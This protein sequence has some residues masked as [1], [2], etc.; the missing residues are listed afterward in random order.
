[1]SPGRHCFTSISVPSVKYDLTNCLRIPIADLLQFLRTQL[2][3]QAVPVL[4]QLIKTQELHR[5]FRQLEPFRLLG[6]NKSA[7][8][9]PPSK[10]RIGIVDVLQKK[11]GLVISAELGRIE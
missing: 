4:I 9:I 5:A 2:P 1:I 10:G 11:D 8:S 7:R 6:Q 3:A